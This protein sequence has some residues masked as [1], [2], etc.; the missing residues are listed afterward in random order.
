MKRYAIVG[1]ALA[2]AS[3]LAVAA[4]RRGEHAEASTRAAADS[5]QVVALGRSD[6]ARAARADL[7]A[8]VP[9][10]GTLAPSLEVRIASPLSEVLEDVLVK[11]GQA[12]H[13][14]QV[15][16]RFRTRALEPAARSAEAQRRLAASDYARMQSLFKKGAVSQRD[17]EAAEVTLRATEATAA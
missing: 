3:L 12:V 17:V 9:V 13:R 16:S 6:V 2:G 15:L 14:G 10:S 11:E 8:G 5:V 7:V 4:A 1:C